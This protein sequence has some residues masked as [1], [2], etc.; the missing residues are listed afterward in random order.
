MAV[1]VLVPL[2]LAVAC[3]AGVAVGI[4]LVSTAR[5]DATLTAEVATARRHSV[6][7]SV[8][9]SVLAGAALVGLFAARSLVASP[10]LQTN[11]VLA[12]LPL[13]AAAVGL[14]VL[15]AG[16]LTW[17]RPTGVVRTALLHD[18]SAATLARGA[19]PRTALVV[20]GLLVGTCGVAGLLADAD[21]RTISRRFPGGGASASPFPGWFYGVPQLLVLACCVALTTAVLV[22]AAR[23]PAVVTAD[24]E[25]DLLLRR[26]SAARACRVLVCAALVT[27]AGD[28]ATAGSRVASIHDTGPAHAAGSVVLVLGLLLLPVAL[29]VA[30]LPVPRLS[31]PR[32]PALA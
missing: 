11:R 10:A 6:L 4:L 12:V 19:W 15:W 1:L 14:L 21:G 7:V 23:R 22:A 13:C 31:R 28:L 26:A 20:T 29:S 25:T 24:V 17:P 30:F 16:E 9:A 8:L 2:L 32:E 27:L 5:P 3:A 18:R